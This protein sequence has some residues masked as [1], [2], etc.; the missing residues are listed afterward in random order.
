MWLPS[1]FGPMSRRHFVRHMAGFSLMAAPSF[2]FVRTL[3]AQ[4]PKMKRDHKSLIIL[5]MGGGPSHM[6]LWDMKPG[7]T[8]GGEF[9]PMKTAASGVEICEHLPTIASQM[10]HLSI[11]RSLSSGEADH[12]RGRQ[13]MHT[14]YTPNPALQFPS[15]GAVTAQ[16]LTPKELA[17]P[18]FITVGGTSEGPG[19]LGMAY[20][21]F[22]VQ[23]AGAPPQNIN[24]PAELGTGAEQ[25]LRQDS[26]FRL[27][28][29]TEDAFR[30]DHGDAAKAHMDTYKKAYDLTASKLKAVFDL[31]YEVDGKPMNPAVKSLYGE[32][33][34]SKGCLLA[35]KLVET[36]VPCVEVDLGGWDNHAQV[37]TALHGGRGNMMNRTGGGGLADRLDKGMGALVKD[38]VERGLWKDTVVVWMGEFGRTP[39]INQNG[40]RD[41][42]ARCWSVV[43]GGGNIKGGQVYGSTTKDG[44]DV[45]DD[46]CS[47]SDLFA[48]IYQGLGISPDTEIR[49]P[50]GRPRKISGDKG[51]TALKGLV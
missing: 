14:A 3:A 30:K 2:Q 51:G 8:T 25:E 46:K 21:P 31:N 35:R 27:L 13:L 49:D 42:W 24:P 48:T 50:L 12:Q 33:G 34:F 28:G 6:D 18:G 20:A 23:S 47:V 4:A 22:T 36:G 19:F 10:K 15:I 43:V 45:K 17:L 39:R 40:G 41:H 26:R 1:V 29:V 11:V 38:L 9:K 5:W 37:F 32:D 16:Q 44:M 7:E